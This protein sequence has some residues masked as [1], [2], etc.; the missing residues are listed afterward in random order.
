MYTPPVVEDDA[1]GVIADPD[2]MASVAQFL[3]SEAASFVAG[4]DLLV[5]GGINKGWYKFAQSSVS[6]HCFSVN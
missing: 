3:R 6:L 5:D 2:E 4:I 1:G